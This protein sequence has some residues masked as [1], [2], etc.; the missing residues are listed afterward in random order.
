MP[1]LADD[2][3]TA[4]ADKTVTVAE[5]YF[6]HGL[7]RPQTPGQY[8]DAL[9]LLEVEGKVAA[10]PPASLRREGTMADHVEIQFPPKG[11]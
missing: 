5:I 11:V 4:F 3:L 7:E 8:K 2:L 6:N 9:K 1:E 10:T